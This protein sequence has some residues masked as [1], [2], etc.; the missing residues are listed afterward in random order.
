MQPALGYIRVSSEQ[1]AGDTHTSL[2]D[3]RAAIGAL[4]ARVGAEVVQVFE[5]PGV[6]GATIA[7]RP[8]LRALISFCQGNKRR[9][10]SPGYVFILNDS[11]LGRFDD[12]DEAAHLRFTLKSLGWI[13]RFAEADDI[14]DPSLRHIMRAVGSA[15]ASEYR[16]NLR[17]NA[18]RGRMGTSKLGYWPTR[19]PY[20]YSRMVVAPAG[21]ERVLGE[22]VPKAKDEKIKLTPGPAFEV[23]LVQDLFAMYATG[24]YSM[25]AL[26]RWARRQVPTAGARPM[27]WSVPQISNMLRNHAY[28]GR[29]AGRARTAERIQMGDHSRREPEYIV[30]GAHV[31]L[32]DRETFDQVQELL[33]QLPPISGKNDY[34]V[35]GLVT[36]VH[37]GE[38]YVGGGLSARLADGSRPL[39]YID[40]GGRDGRCG[41][42]AGCVGLHI[43]ERAV[44]DGLAA[45]VAGQVTEKAI[46]GAFADRLK[47]RDESPAATANP[48]K[49]IEAL[50]QR[51][52]RLIAAVEVGTL[53]QHEAGP[54]LEALRMELARLEAERG[55]L[56]TTV[57]TPASVQSHLDV[58]V[59]RAR[60]L[61]SLARVATGPELR[62]LLR[63]WMDS[64][65]FDRS[66][67]VLTMRMRTLPGL[68]LAATSVAED[69]R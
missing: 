52:E 69:S 42:P 25:N 29:I 14:A 31:A 39:F 34:R 44:I 19:N 47:A 54:R 21:R 56:N 40:R 1:Q 4:A 33:A 8:G 24:A 2:A 51:R 43:L 10:D 27:K 15:Q 67:R 58:L 7:K 3:Q 9:L 6:S 41:P 68:L 11:R 22:G 28:I 57:V 16:R 62:A 30:E 17:A 35:R 50:V 13:V 36:C 63:P 12:P 5:D 45:H 60:D 37:C 18:T 55:A 48:A 59:K 61:V 38:P 65:T 26:E 53:Q 20:G 64:M 46:R 49:A 32:V 66:T 23:Q